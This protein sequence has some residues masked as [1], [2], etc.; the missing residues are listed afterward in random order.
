VVASSWPALLACGATAGLFAVAGEGLA[1]AVLGSAYDASVGSQLG[2]LVAALSP[3]MV[4]TIVL[5]VA[6]PLVFVVE[7]GGRLPVLA[8]LMTGVHLPLVWAGERVAGL[9]GVAG[10]LAVSTAV[11]LAGLLPLV[12]SVAVVARGTGGAAAL[13]AAFALV[14][15]GGA[16]LA[17][18]GGIVAGAAGLGLYLLL[19]ALVRPTGLRR[20]LRDL[21]RVG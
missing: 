1:S 12:G 15:F 4:V 6:L 18:G 2:R 14:G 8:G 5:S 13:V 19:V 16:R 17:L 9:S 21:R 20:S 10:A 3:W 11:G 7:R